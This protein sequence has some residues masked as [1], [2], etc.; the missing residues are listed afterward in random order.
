MFSQEVIRMKSGFL[1]MLTEGYIEIVFSVL[2]N[3]RI[4]VL[5]SDEVATWF[6][7][8]GNVLNLT[9][10]GCGTFGVFVVPVYVSYH[11]YKHHD[12]LHD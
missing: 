8:F 7:S 9:C 6:N 3:I 12:K 1:V 2:I 10:L 4:F 5:T 11:I